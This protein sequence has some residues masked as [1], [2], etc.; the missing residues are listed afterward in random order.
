MP[1][2]LIT[3]ASTGLGA[4]FARILAS[5]HY[6]LILVARNEDRLKDLGNALKASHGIS[7]K[8]IKSDLSQPGAAQQIFQT[9]GGQGLSLDVL[10]NNAGCGQWGPFAQSDV[11]TLNSMITLNMNALTEMTRL[12][13]PDMLTRKSGRVLNVASTAAFQP[14]PWMAAYYASKSYV[15]SLGE[16]LAVE[17]RGTGV[18]VSTFCPGPTK[19][20]FFDRAQ[21]GRSRL[22]NMLFADS[23]TCA[24]NGVRGMMRGQ[25][26]IIDGWMNWLLAQSGRF[27]PRFALRNVAGMINSAAD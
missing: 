20:E 22:K 17:L 23:F 11:P 8:T 12:A 9:V 7:F 6:D 10:I 27:I 16:A 19:T 25:T 2:A 15:L 5:M 24:Q 26:I 18:S 3:G 4:D 21:M 1:T 14:G 13:L